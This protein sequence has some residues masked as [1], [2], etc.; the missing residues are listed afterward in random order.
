MYYLSI[1]VIKIVKNSQFPAFDL[2]FNFVD[3]T[4]F[5]T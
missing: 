5:G 4:I 2:L 1:G 3:Y